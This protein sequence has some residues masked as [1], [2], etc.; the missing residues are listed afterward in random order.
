MAE[1]E[2]KP[3][4]EKP[5]EEKPVEEK[6]V[7]EK[8]VEEKPVE[9]K[10]IIDEKDSKGNARAAS[11]DGTPLELE[12][13]EETTD[14]KEGIEYFDKM[15]K[16]YKA[17]NI[18]EVLDIPTNM[19]ANNLSTSYNSLAVFKTKIQDEQIKR[20]IYE[21]LSDPTI[22]NAYDHA[23]NL[24]QQP[25]TS[26]SGSED[27]VNITPGETA[28]AA[29]GLQNGLS[30][31]VNFMTKNGSTVAMM[32]LL[33]LVQVGQ[34]LLGFFKNYLS[35]NYKGEEQQVAA[36][37]NTML[38]I[39]Q[40]AKQFEDLVTNPDPSQ[41]IAIKLAKMAASLGFTIDTI[42]FASKDYIDDAITEIIGIFQK[43]ME[44]LIHA[45]SQ[46]MNTAI[47]GIPL[48]GSVYALVSSGLRVAELF[49]VSV[50]GAMNIGDRIRSTIMNVMGITSKAFE[51]EKTVSSALSKGKGMQNPA[52]GL[53]KDTS[54][55]SMVEKLAEAQAHQRQNLRKT[56]MKFEGD[57][58]SLDD[59]SPSPSP[60]PEGDTESSPA[61]E[62]MMK[63]L[64][65]F[66][67][68][69]LAKKAEAG[70]E[71]SEKTET[72]KQKGGKNKSFKTPWGDVFNIK[73]PL[74]ANQITTR[75]RQ[76]FKRRR[77]VSNRIHSMLDHL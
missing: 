12:E 26:A 58:A 67:D 1:K 31:G 63:Q 40:N 9:E 52:P 24:N 17:R 13:E 37:Q 46:L 14:P 76:L 23:K 47:A 6:P 30:T 54:Y 56:L 16:D 7:E 15:A 66:I 72:I 65:N 36:F 3:V 42:A 39:I 48:I 34:K 55:T 4:E 25:S 49:G 5:V 28:I 20:K 10:P 21:Y 51:P 22:R 71:K 73:F 33:G 59:I 8:P 53:I 29:A 77:D 70:S 43:T 57:G 32:G 35:G 44:K 50:T 11:A 18:Y 68:E 27:P 75:H 60:S 61:K 2:E 74:Q 45:G 38:S 62:E 19:T 64:G 41:N 69:Y